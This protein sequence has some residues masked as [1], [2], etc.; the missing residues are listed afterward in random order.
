D[1]ATTT[2][3]KLNVIM[4]EWYLASWGNG[5]EPYNFYR[6]TGKPD[7]LQL[8]LNPTPGSFIRSFFYPAVYAN[9]NNTATQK[10]TTGVK[11][12]WD[13]NPDNFIK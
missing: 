11:V 3:D 6:R 4:K 5:V 12:F 2:G 7:N 8:A 9:L 10:A 13:T 1:A